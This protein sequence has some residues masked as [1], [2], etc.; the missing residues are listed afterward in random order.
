[1]SS[2]SRLW[3]GLPPTDTPTVAFK[4]LNCSSHVSKLPFPSYSLRM[5]AIAIN[6]IRICGPTIIPSSLLETDAPADSSRFAGFVRRILCS[7]AILRRAN[8]SSR[9]T[10]S[11]SRRIHSISRCYNSL[12]LI[13]SFVLHTADIM[14]APFGHPWIHGIILHQTSNKLKLFALAVDKSRVLSFSFNSATVK[15]LESG[16]SNSYCCQS[17][18]PLATLHVSRFALVRNIRNRRPRSPPL[19]SPRFSSPTWTRHPSSNSLHTLRIA[20]RDRLTLLNL[21]ASRLRTYC[22]CFARIVSAPIFL[23]PDSHELSIIFC[24][25]RLSPQ[26]YVIYSICIYF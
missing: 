23:S 1:M 2:R 7:I 24:W 5:S 13:N 21:H 25:S 8:S 4:N 18:R 22:L 10:S 17:S 6:F 12:A 14:I 11:F 26:I 9:S 16:I 15:M 20:P 3:H 19:D